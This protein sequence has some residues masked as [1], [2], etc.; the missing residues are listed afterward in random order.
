MKRK[1]A[2]LFLLI[3]Y[4]AANLLNAQS[5]TFERSY[6][7][8]EEPSIVGLNVIELPDG[9][10]LIAGSR[11]DTYQYEKGT[12]S[13]FIL[14]KIDKNGYT[15]WRKEVETIQSNFRPS[16]QILITDENE[17]VISS[18]KNIDSI[19]TLNISSLDFDGNEISSQ[20]LIT[21]STFNGCAIKSTEG[22][23]YLI[24]AGDENYHRPDITVIKLNNR[25]EINWQ[26]RFY[27]ILPNIYR[28]SFFTI[29]KWG[30]DG[31][32]IGR[33]KEIL[34]I[35]SDGDSLIYINKLH[36]FISETKEGD[37]LVSDNDSLYR[38][39][40]DG[41]VI[42]SYGFE[43]NPGPAI[44]TS[45][46]RYLVCLY[47]SGGYYNFSG[48]ILKMDLDGNIIW[49]TDVQGLSFSITELNDHS[50][51]TTGRWKR[52]WDNLQLLHNFWV[53]K[54]DSFGNYS[55]INLLTPI[56]GENLLTFSSY[57]INW[58]SKEVEKVNLYFSTDDGRDWQTIVAN[59]D[60]DTSEFTW[61]IPLVFTDSIKLKI[62]DSNNPAIYN[63]T[64]NPVYI[65]IY[66]PTDFISINEI[67]MWV[68]N[69]GMGSHDPRTDGN[70]FYWPGGDTATKSAIFSDGLAWG[71]KLNGEI[72]VNGSL[73]R[74]GLKPGRILPDGTADEDP[75]PNTKIFKIRRDW[76]SLPEG[77]LK[78]RLKY[79]YN[80]WPIEAG[81]PWDDLNKDGIYT[82]G[83]DKPKFIGDETLWYVCN[84]LDT[85]QSRHTYGSDPIGLEIQTTVF[86]FERDD[87]KD[88]VFKKYK[89]I[90]K[91]GY[92]IEDMYF[93][94]FADD[95]L[96][97][98]GDDYEGFDTTFNLS[99]IFNGDN[100]DG[101]GS[102]GSY[103]TPPPAVGH[104]LVQGPR[105]EGEISDSARYRDGWIAGYKNLG[106]TSSGILYKHSHIYPSPPPQAIYEG[107]L[108]FYG[109]MMGLNW[110]GGPI[111]NPITGEP[112]NWALTGD[113]VTGTGWYD[114]GDWPN[115]VLP[116]DRKY[117]L[118][119]GP[120]TMA[121]GD[122]QE[123]AIAIIIARG[124]DNIN[125][126][127]ELRNLAAHVQNFYDTE[128]VEIL[129]ETEIIAPEGFALY[130]NY[131]NPFNNTTTIEYEVPF[132]SKVGIKLYDILGR[133]VK[134][135]VNNEEKVKWR[136]KLE[137]DASGLAS[138][139][140]FY[141]MKAGDFIQTKKMV[142]LR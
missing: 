105:I 12:W 142:L 117:F 126:I 109:Y 9:N 45:D 138:G 118:P 139:V 27:V 56:G 49:S 84:D 65:A 6:P 63:F 48:S 33:R 64:E 15:I 87:L 44:Q 112:T 31:Y 140:Y 52:L 3:F 80:H 122:T 32:A 86:G 133:E 11:S 119:S 30:S 38:I 18:I 70:G 67:L 69:N 28:G 90:N 10:Y 107:T 93:S 132:N 1:F 21:D 4:F 95:D 58:Y 89:V 129:K 111:I 74:T 141:R 26:K 62:E 68:W 35:N 135:L 73:H 130:Q 101:G 60:A 36:N 5:V 128:L 54:T 71:G 39:N 102:G 81:A 78:E 55:A 42:W 110:D 53:L 131:P 116:G 104:M 94:Y 83:F 106:M 40:P 82:P 115:S 79:D 124:T 37:I 51:L 113:P 43:Y 97:D 75:S 136:Y 46:G 91:S 114:G 108:E 50:L 7:S 41:N 17:I 99:Y 24:V 16:N 8:F 22:G 59:L 137:F 96:G 120:F 98:A 2:M 76:Q 29:N 127:T 125:S 88:V 20:N 103:G 77:I 72:R 25:L 47:E 34:K 14:M 61:E 123:V 19:N 85:A 23:G 57:D 66:Q 92:P 121:P 13:N 100:D 134:I